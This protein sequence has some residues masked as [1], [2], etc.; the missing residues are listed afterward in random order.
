LID[1]GRACVTAAKSSPALQ[2]QASTTDPTGMDGSTPLPAAGATPDTPAI[3]LPRLWSVAKH[4]VPNLIEC[5]LVPTLIFSLM[6]HFSG[7]I[8]ASLV[9]LGW[10]YAMLL[11]RLITKSRI[12]GLLL[13]TC[14]GLT[15][16]TGVV[17]AS[18]SA[19]IYFLQPIAATAMVGLTFLVSTMT[20]SPMV[21]RLANDF[22]PLTDDIVARRRVKVLFRR[23]TILWAG[24]NLVNAAVTCWLLLSQST[25]VFVAVK[26]FPAMGVTWCAVGITVL[27]ALR[28]ARQEGLHVGRGRRGAP[29][30]SPA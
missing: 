5:T 17:V 10:A 15:V 21:D 16:R 4:A 29:A 23:L 12:P 22:C 28:V 20:R 13:L 2:Y 25:A 24:V 6:L 27:W 18:G 9:A 26:P 14:L 3:A 8:P 7:L 30:L 19:F 11:R 1:G